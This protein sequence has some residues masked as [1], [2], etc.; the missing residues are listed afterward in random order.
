MSQKI[1]MEQVVYRAPKVKKETYIITKR[2]EQKISEK[3]LKE[4]F[5]WIKKNCYKNND[6]QITVE[7]IRD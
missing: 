5:T 2:Y 1:N 3:D 6:T 7:I 4:L